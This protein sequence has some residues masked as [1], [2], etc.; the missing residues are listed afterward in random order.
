MDIVESLSLI[1]NK[2]LEYIIFLTPIAVFS[3]I[4]I[5]ISTHGINILKALLLMF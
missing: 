5:S 2:I 1:F 3:L 4:G